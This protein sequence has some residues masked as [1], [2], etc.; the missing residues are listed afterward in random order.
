MMNQIVNCMIAGVGGQGTVFASKLIAEAAISYGLS[1][2][3]TETIG[4]AQRGG[5]VVSHIRMGAQIHSPLIPLHAADIILAFEPAE[6]VRLLPYLT[7]KGIIIVCSSIIKPVT[8]S[9]NQD[10]YNAET[11]LSFLTQQT[12]QLIIIDTAPLLERCGSTKPLNVA[13][14]GAASKCGIFPFDELLL[15]Q[16]IQAKTPERF[17]QMNL[18]AFQLGKELYA[19]S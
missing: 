7:E 4:M 1:V 3:T 15:E 12:K 17:L 5:S 8:S 18:N 6:G 14:L 2:R 10:N 9:L 13:I 11:M 16:A 19:L